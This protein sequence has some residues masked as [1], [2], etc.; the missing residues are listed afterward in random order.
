MLKI[1]IVAGE[2]SGDHLGAD[3]I[4]LMKKT[5]PD[6]ELAGIGGPELIGEGCYSLYPM[7][8]LSVMGIVEILKHLPELLRIRAGLKRYFLANPPDIFIGIDSPD[9]NLPL[10]KFLRANGTRTVHYVS[11][12]VWA[13][14]EGRL[15]TIARAVDLMLTVFP[16]EKQYYDNRNIQAMYVGHPLARSIPL[17][18]DLH[19]A[20]Q[21]L[22]IDTQSR[23]IAIL[24]SSAL[25]QYGIASSSRRSTS[26]F[27][28]IPSRSLKARTRTKNSQYS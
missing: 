21:S 19:Q 14:R 17:V 6:L 3:L 20:R 28:V 8:K 27:I 15:K 13:W 12:T 18:N 16:F 1:G 26:R 23:F 9:F 2:P 11:P 25:Q 5:C 22:G 4:R 7:E 24:P 10:E